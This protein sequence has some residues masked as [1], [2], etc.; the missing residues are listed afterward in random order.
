M[1]LVDFGGVVFL[2]STQV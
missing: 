1:P 2:Q